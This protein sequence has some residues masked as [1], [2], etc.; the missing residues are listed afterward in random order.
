MEELDNV[1][2]SISKVFILC[3]CV[4]VVH[5][6]V[7]VCMHVRLHTYVYV[8]KCEGHMFSSVVHLSY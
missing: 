4:C 5:A 7:D 6:H 1:V 8:H 2:V 3:A